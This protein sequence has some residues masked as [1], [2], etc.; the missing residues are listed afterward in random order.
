MLC[1]NII[2]FKNF[3]NNSRCPEQI[4]TNIIGKVAKQNKNN[5]IGNKAITVIQ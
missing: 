5:L 2:K 3:S 4:L 1:E